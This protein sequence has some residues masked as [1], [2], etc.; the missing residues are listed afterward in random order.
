MKTPG[1]EKGS[2]KECLFYLV[3]RLPHPQSHVIIVFAPETLQEKHC[4][5]LSDTDDDDFM[6]NFMDAEMAAFD[7][8]A[9]NRKDVHSEDSS[10]SKPKC[11]HARPQP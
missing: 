4:M 3:S 11:K 10:E 8:Q 6:A 7:R 5:Q 9:K 1:K 2:A